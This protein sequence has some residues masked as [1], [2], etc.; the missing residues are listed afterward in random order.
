MLHKTKLSLVRSQ[1]SD[2]LLPEGCTCP[3]LRGLRDPKLIWG[4]ISLGIDRSRGSIR[5]L[6]TR[7]G[8][9]FWKLFIRKSA[10]WLSK[11]SYAETSFSRSSMSL[12]QIGAHS[13]MLHIFNSVASE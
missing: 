3:G 4:L 2:T 13:G 8:N 1:T 11:I 6:P 5:K 7:D 12:L 9:S 10:T